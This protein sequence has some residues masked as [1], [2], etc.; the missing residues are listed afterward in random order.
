VRHG[1]QPELNVSVRA[2]KWRKRGDSKAL[3][4]SG[5]IDITP[6]RAVALARWALSTE[7]A[8]SEFFMI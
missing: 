7:A 3:D 4:L 5:E 1:N 8:P 6:L 2:A